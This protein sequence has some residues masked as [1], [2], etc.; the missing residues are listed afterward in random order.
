MDS[1]PKCTAEMVS[2]SVVPTHSR[3]IRQV[4][5]GRSGHAARRFVPNMSRFH[6]L[7][8]LLLFSVLVSRSR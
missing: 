2:I 5:A 7:G 8:P 3:E 4:R 1:I 6:R